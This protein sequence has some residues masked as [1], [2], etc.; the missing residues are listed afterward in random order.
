MTRCVSL[1]FQSCVEQTYRERI[2]ELQDQNQ[3][4]DLRIALLEE[5]LQKLQVGDFVIR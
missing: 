3:R 2:A 4:K 1:S 5:K